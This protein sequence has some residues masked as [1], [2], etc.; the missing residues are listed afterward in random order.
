MLENLLKYYSI[1][2]PLLT[3]FR[4]INSPDTKNIMYDLFNRIISG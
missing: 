1:P 4:V 3:L 2:I